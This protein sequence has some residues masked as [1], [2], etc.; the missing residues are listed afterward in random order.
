MIEVITLTTMGAAISAPPSPLTPYPLPRPLRLAVVPPLARRPRYWHRPKIV[1]FS[2]DPI[3]SLPPEP[4]AL[5][6]RP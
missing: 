5:Q 2:P 1:V 3:P 6:N 4:K